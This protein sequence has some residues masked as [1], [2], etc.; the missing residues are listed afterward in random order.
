MSSRVFP[1]HAPYIILPQAKQLAQEP[2]PYHAEVP[3]DG[4]ASQNPKEDVFL[5]S[6]WIR[7][8]T[9]QRLLAQIQWEQSPCIRSLPL[10]KPSKTILP[11]TEKR[12]LC[13]AVEN[14]FI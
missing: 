11:I 2:P 12:I 14:L 5:T 6:M 1:Q 8:P 7:G 4:R 3:E 13:P 9:Q 10:L